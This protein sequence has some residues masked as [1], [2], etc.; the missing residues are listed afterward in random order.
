MPFISFRSPRRYVAT[1]F[2][3]L[4]LQTVYL[5]G[6]RDKTNQYKHN[7]E[8]DRGSH[9]ER[10]SR[11]HKPLLSLTPPEC[12]QDRRDQED[13]DGDA[14]IVCHTVLYGCHRPVME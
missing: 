6:K 11:R 2:E 7:T 14:E 3:R 12:E 10:R 4:R 1:L 5:R 8:C 13:H 9:S